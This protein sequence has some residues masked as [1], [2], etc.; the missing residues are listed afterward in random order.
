MEEVQLELSEI[1]G[2]FTVE[3]N[4]VSA[5]DANALE[6]DLNSALTGMK[7]IKR[8]FF[9][10]DG[11]SLEARI[12]YD[13]N[14]EYASIR[15]GALSAV[16]SAL[17]GQEFEFIDPRASLNGSISFSGV[18][19]AEL[20]STAKDVFFSYGLDLELWQ[21]AYFDVNSLTDTTTGK[22]FPLPE[23]QQELPI[24]VE[25]GSE[26]GKE[27]LIQVLFQTIRDQVTTVYAAEIQG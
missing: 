4:L 9:H 5:E 12:T 23:D 6:Q 1:E 22:E 25:P 27:L 14:I 21:Q 8:I 15:P 26:Q 11:N 13:K 16:E 24:R 17:S 10:Q 2:A 19:A 7:G 18:S 3:I 20:A